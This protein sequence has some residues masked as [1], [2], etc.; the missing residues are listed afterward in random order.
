MDDPNYQD[1]VKYL[2]E[3]VQGQNYKGKKIFIDSY[4]KDA[5]S[6]IIAKYGIKNS[7]TN[8]SNFVSTLNQL[9]LNSNIRY[10]VGKWNIK[11]FQTIIRY[12]NDRNK[13]IFI[14]IDFKNDRFVFK[15]TPPQ[16]TAQR[17]TPVPRTPA[18]ASALARTPASASASALA[19]ARLPSHIQTSVSK[20]T[21]AILEN[22]LTIIQKMPDDYIFYNVN[23]H[24]I[25]DS[26]IDIFKSQ[27]TNED[28]RKSFQEYLNI[29]GNCNPFPLLVYYIEHY[30][31]NYLDDDLYTKYT[32]I[33]LS[34]CQILNILSTDSGFYKIFNIEIKTILLSDLKQKIIPAIE[35]YINSN[36]K[37]KQGGTFKIKNYKNNKNS[38]KN[39]K[40]KKSKTNKK[41]NKP[42][43]S[44]NY[45]KN[46]KSKK[47][48][49]SKK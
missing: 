7:F 5:I 14:D 43:K 19:L 45:Y 34:V 6:A 46:K 42:Y 17:P 23:Q 39:K 11:Q 44:K 37:V 36:T 35:E 13:N 8:K 24:P 40:S 41:T 16:Q 1:F 22:M 26:S 2:D 10:E 38:Y 47:S 49:K 48:K 25:Y 4:V 9:V 30:I 27:I 21:S 31:L 33:G 29:L 12:C 18:P 15:S 20:I 3:L 28:N 32:T